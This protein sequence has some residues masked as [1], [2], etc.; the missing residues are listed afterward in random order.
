MSM[1]VSSAIET[2]ALYSAEFAR[3]A[4]SDLAPRVDLSGRL[5]YATDSNQDLIFRMGA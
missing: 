4:A 2:R 3:P 1:L 5:F